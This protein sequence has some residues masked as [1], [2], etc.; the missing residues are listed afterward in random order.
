VSGAAQLGVA[1][2]RD[3]SLL[4]RGGASASSSALRERGGTRASML[5]RLHAPLLVVVAASALGGCAYERCTE[6]GCADGYSLSVQAES[7]LLPNGRYDVRVTPKDA[8]SQE[9]HFVVSDTGCASGHCVTESSCNASYIVGYQE[10]GLP[11]EVII[12]YPLFDDSVAVVVARDSAV[13][14]D[15]V[16]LP[17]YREIQPNG[18]ECGPTCLVG[19]DTVHVD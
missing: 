3:A 12:G 15:A 8:S 1:G 11:D 18:P 9:C 10:H 19:V 4:V 2:A 13:V 14:F 17:E 16:L 6:A 7:G 5:T